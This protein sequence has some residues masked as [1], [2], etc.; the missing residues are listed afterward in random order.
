[1]FDPNLHFNDGV[2]LPILETAYM[3]TAVKDAESGTAQSEVSKKAPGQ[4]EAASPPLRKRT[5]NSGW[6]AGRILSWFVPPLLG[7][8]IIYGWRFASSFVS[9]LR[10]TM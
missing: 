9:K 5:R 3:V 6:R 7:L 10:C 2:V 4:L 1:M 8:F